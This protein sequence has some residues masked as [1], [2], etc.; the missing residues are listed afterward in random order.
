MVLHLKKPAD[1]V[2]A[3]CLCGLDVAQIIRLRLFMLCP[4]DAQLPEVIE[5]QE[6]WEA[7]GI[8]IVNIHIAVVAIFSLDVQSRDDIRCV[9]FP[10]N[11]VQVL[12]EVQFH[13]RIIAIQGDD[14][15]GFLVAVVDGTC[16]EQLAN[17]RNQQVSTALVLRLQGADLLRYA[18]RFIEGLA[19]SERPTGVLKNLFQQVLSR[20]DTVGIIEGQEQVFLGEQ[21]ANVLA[22]D[23]GGHG[24]S[25]VGSLRCVQ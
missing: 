2:A 25:L 23:G 10:I 22:G 18:I 14:A 17:V 20:S 4:E 11:A 21:G 1:R 12:P 7:G 19:V 13:H 9:F 16:T 5:I 24:Q 15:D 3:A 6:E 8:H